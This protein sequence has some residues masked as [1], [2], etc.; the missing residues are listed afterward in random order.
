MKPSTRL[1][2]ARL[3]ALALALATLAA[4]PLAPAQAVT[5]Q[6][7]QI[8]LNDYDGQAI[9]Q[10][11]SSGT[12]L[13]SFAGTG[14]SWSGIAITPTGSLVTASRSGPSEIKL[15]ADT[16]SLTGS[17]ASV[18]GVQDVSVFADGTLAVTTFGITLTRYSPAGTL[19]GTTTLPGVSNAAG[20]TVGSDNILYIADAGNA[21][22]AK[23][24]ASGAFLGTFALGFNAADLVMSPLDGTLWISNASGGTIHHYTTAGAALGSFATGFSG[25]AFGIGIAPDGQSLYSVSYTSTAV[26]HLS[27]TGTLLDSFTVPTG[28][29][30]MTVVPAPEP[31]SALLLAGAG[32]GLLARRR[33]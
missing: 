12:L 8:L 32:A 3:A 9:R 28:N 15:F 16:G 25:S 11:S 26:R 6:P 14:S 2:S 5:L 10:Y 31:G 21:Q 30:L 17:F 4:L 23:V 7:G 29:Y 27:L 33:R 22:I 1:R 13:Q 24:N 18:S 19:L 20:T